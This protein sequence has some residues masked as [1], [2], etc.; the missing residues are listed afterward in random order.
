MIEL[1][2]AVS[3]SFFVGAMG[4]ML[5]YYWIRPV[6]SY[7]RLKKKIATLIHPFTQSFGEIAQRP[8]PKA[9]RE[10]G[11][12]VSDLFNDKLPLWY[13]LTLVRRKEDPIEA[14]KR[15]ASL[16]NTRNPE[17]AAVTAQKILELLHIR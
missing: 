15:L 12:A 16:S 4:Y 2:I 10:V 17:Q 6:A 5:S 3:V 7:R 8:D 11:S 9:L 1:F 13:R 14:A